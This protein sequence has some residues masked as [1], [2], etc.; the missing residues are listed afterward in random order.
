MIELKTEREAAALLA[1]S[2]RTLADWRL[3]GKGPPYVK[4][5]G[6]IRYRLDDLEAFVSARVIAR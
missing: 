3:D 4:L 5:H 1:V 6:A 2:P